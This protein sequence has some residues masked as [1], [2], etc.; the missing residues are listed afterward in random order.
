MGAPTE[1]TSD[2]HTDIYMDVKGLADRYPGVSTATVYAWLHKGTA[3][4]S[5]KIG[6][7]R[8][9]RIEDVVAWENEHADDR[10]AA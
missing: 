10:P 1:G 8:F 6:K 2:T 3:P 9:F 4:R 5:V 7:R